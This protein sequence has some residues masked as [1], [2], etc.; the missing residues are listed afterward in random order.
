M[1]NISH[2]NLFCIFSTQEQ[3]NLIDLTTFMKTDSFVDPFDKLWLKVIGTLCYI[4][5]LCNSKAM[6]SN[7][8]SAIPRPPG[9]PKTLWETSFALLFRKHHIV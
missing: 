1:K 9:G 5:Q 4:I 2:P 3:Y 6:P 8:S 7:P